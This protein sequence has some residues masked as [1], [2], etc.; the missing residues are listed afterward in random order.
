MAPVILLPA[1]L[2][3][4]TAAVSDGE[5]ARAVV[6]VEASVVATRRDIHAHPELSNRE[7]RT[8]ALVRDRLRALGL[9]VRYPVARTGVVG[10]LRGARP[11]PAI[12]LRADLDALPIDEHVDVP[13]KSQNAGVM[14]A[15]GHDAHTAILLGAAEVLVGLKAR[16]SGTI[17]FLFQ[18]AEEGPPEGEPGG[19]ALMIREGVLDD[20]KVSAIFAL[21]VNPLLEAGVIGWTD[22]P[23]FASSDRFVIEVKGRKT[24]GAYPHLGLDPIPVAAEM[25]SALQTIV[26]REIDSQSPK[27]L[28]VGAIHGGNRFNIIADGVTVEGTFRAL[29]PAVR[30]Q[31]RERLLRT[32]RGVAEAHAT[33]AE[34]RFTDGHAA[35]VND[36]ELARAMVPALERALG[37]T[38]VVR[39]RPEMGAEDFADFAERV[40]GLY[41]RLG[42][43]NEARGITASVHSAEF[44][45]DETALP[46]GVRALVALALESLG[47]RAGPR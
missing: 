12:A 13:F 24:H 20:P 43:R 8:G 47:R 25:V 2:L 5:V 23:I 22:G 21:H 18:P 26:S 14:H 28:S 7:E 39:V 10:I 44:D 36:A 38:R 19:A 9:E 35:T 27:V 31:L 42:V 45:L 33:T 37:A 46:A 17:V 15:C 3:A 40:P 16:L 1:V 32:V 4:A 6:R 11:G 41:V 30:T 29:D 34:V